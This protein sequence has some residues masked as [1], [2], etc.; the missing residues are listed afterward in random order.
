MMRIFDAKKYSKGQVIFALLFF[1]ILGGLYLRISN[2]SDYLIYPDSYQSILVAKNLMDG[3]GLVGL[4]G[5]DGM[6]YPDTFWWTRPLYS[7]FIVTGSFFESDLI[8][9]AGFISLAAGVLAIPLMYVL[10]KQIYS[11]RLA[12]VAGSILITV[13][14]SH[15]IWSGFVLTETTSV[16]LALGYLYALFRFTG[17]TT[18][19]GDPKLLFV[20]F[21]LALTVL[22]RY[23]YIALLVPTVYLLLFR[24]HKPSIIL[25]NII[26]SFTFIII[27]TLF[28]IGKLPFSMVALIS[29]TS[30][31]AILVA[32][33]MLSIYLIYRFKNI[34]FD[35]HTAQR[36][37]LKN[38]LTI[39]VMLLVLMLAGALSSAIDFSAFVDFISKDFLIM[40]F[41]VIGVYALYEKKT[42]IH[43]LYFCLLSILILIP[44]YYQVNPD[45]FR[46][47]THLLPYLVIPASYGVAHTLRRLSSP[48]KYRL[49]IFITLSGILLLQTL[50][51]FQGLKGFKGGL[52]HTQGYEQIAASTL[53]NNFEKNDMLLVSMPEPY[54]LFTDIPTHSISL[55]YPYIANLNRLQGKQKITIVSDM[56]MKTYFPEFYDF[57]EREMDPY[58]LEE[59]YI[60][61]PFRIQ[62]QIINEYVP[63]KIYSVK[64][65]ELNQKIDK[66]DPSIR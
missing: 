54:Y 3:Y 12:A 48:S 9:S 53:V 26:A 17:K 58:L 64:I 1:L 36:S 47:W 15:V 30:S 7:L 2:I 66:Q 50:V 23:E 57:L 38:T 6:M 59:Y 43:I 42:E 29:Q 16:A 41:F 37:K 11:D 24:Q 25:I 28:Y 5:Y 63:V 55:S 31:Y 13:S 4:L 40:L 39:L 62:N 35:E 18:Y 32:I 19:L 34:S 49:V 10:L 22:A 65:A 8:R 45:M 44:I 56:G 20:G 51:S 27:F 33:T 14:G 52:W 61:Q 46:Y 21:L 60:N